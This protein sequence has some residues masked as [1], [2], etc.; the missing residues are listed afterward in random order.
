MIKQRIKTVTQKSVALSILDELGVCRPYMLDFEAN[1][2]VYIFDGL[3]EPRRIDNNS[4]L[5]AV[6]RGIEQQSGVKVYAV[7]HEHLCFDC[8]VDEVFSFL[9]V[10]K[11][12]E[13]FDCMHRAVGGFHYVYAYCKN[14]THS[15]NSEFGTVVVSAVDGK[16]IR[17]G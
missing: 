2:S 6:I 5:S 9:C 13:D 1:D 10:S 7:T 11:Y 14:V 12:A 17:V 8:H 3:N 16:I 4:L 15:E